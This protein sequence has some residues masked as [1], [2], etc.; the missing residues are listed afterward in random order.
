MTLGAI[1]QP[2]VAQSAGTVQAGVAGAVRGD[3]RLVALASQPAV[4]G[5]SVGR[6]VSSG[7]RIFL[8]DKIETGPQAGLQIMLL[9]ETIFTIGPNAAMVI[10]KFVYDP[11]TEGGEVT[12]SIVKGAFRFVSGRIAKRNPSDMNLRVGVEVGRSSGTRIRA[13][14][15]RIRAAGDR[16]IPTSVQ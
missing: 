5:A 1:G 7:D 14:W 9:D 6:V 12:A 4:A 16:T 15:I 2:A 11:S 3:V 10:D 8:G 13:G